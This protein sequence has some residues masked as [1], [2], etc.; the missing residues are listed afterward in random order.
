[1]GGMFSKP[2]LPKPPPPPEKDIDEES[3]EAADRARRRLRGRY[4]REGTLL[5]GPMSDNSGN[6]PG[7]KSAMG[8]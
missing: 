2:D 4:G 5:T 1:M 7:N 3:N 6:T 8:L